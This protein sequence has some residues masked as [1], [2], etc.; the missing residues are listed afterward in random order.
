MLAHA[1]ALGLPVVE[2]VAAATWV[3]ADTLGLT[4]RGRLEAGAVAHVLI[5]DAEWRA[6][7]VM[8][9]GTWLT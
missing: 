9:R 3:P 5:V 4:G 2:A 1:V 7:R 6:K 8:A